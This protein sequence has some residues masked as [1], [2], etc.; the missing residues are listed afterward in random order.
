MPKLQKS[1][2]LEITVEQ[3]LNACSPLE[4][5]EINMRLDTY[6][7]KSKQDLSKH[8][9]YY[10]TPNSFEMAKWLEIKKIADEI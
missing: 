9:G 7:K 4:L 1:F 5:E 10:P 6:L 8:T 2:H 3:F